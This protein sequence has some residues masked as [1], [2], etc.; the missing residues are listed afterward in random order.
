M[1]IFSQFVILALVIVDVILLGSVLL[2]GNTV[3]LLDPRGIIALR[4]RTLIITAVVLGLCVVL[5]VL[6][7]TFFIAW[8]YRAGNTKAPYVPDSH[9]SAFF[10]LTWWAIPASVVIILAVITWKDTHA[11]DPYKP[12][13]TSVKPLTIQ[14]VSLRWKWLFLY[15]QQHIAT[16]NFV[17]FPA[18][19]PI[20]FALTSDASMNSFWIPQLGGQIYTMAGMQ[21]Q[22]HLMA[23]APGDY[24]G[25]A[26][27]ISG[28]GFSGMNFIAKASSQADFD[29]WI[30]SVKQSSNVLGLA[31]YNKLEEPSENNP[32]AFYSLSEENLYNSIMMKYMAPLHPTSSQQMGNG[33]NLD[34]MPEM[35]M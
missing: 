15:P 20:N 31:E 22:L 8:K 25:S 11:L 33:N 9:H 28:R 35:G 3:A 14:V 26:A 19:V 21:T 34:M 2:H 27:E 16:V 29:A 5:P 23:D 30:Q 10:E 24:H 18:R 13:E 32:P 7:L 12:L 4:E 17:Q 1:N 6:A